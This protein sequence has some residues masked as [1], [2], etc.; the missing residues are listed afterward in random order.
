MC[1]TKIL[2]RGENMIFVM[3]LS[4]AVERYVF[5]LLSYRLTIIDNVRV[6]CSSNIINR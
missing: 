6:I 1:L 3:A 2:G 5:P 4:V